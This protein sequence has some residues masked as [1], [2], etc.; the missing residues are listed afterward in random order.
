MT[1]LIFEK[2]LLWLPRVKNAVERQGLH[3]EIIRSPQEELPPA[4][5]AVINLADHCEELEALF[6]QLKSNGTE[7]L[8]HCSHSEAALIQSARA[9]GFK[10]I[11]ANGV[12]ISRLEQELE[13]LAAED[14]S[15]SPNLEANGTTP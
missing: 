4:S 1:V 9:A 15:T 2:N 11:F 12:F 6:G 5:L 13:R 14:A 8:A 10:K 3:P 7:A